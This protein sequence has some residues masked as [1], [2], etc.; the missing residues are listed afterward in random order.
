MVTCQKCGG[1]FQ[2][3]YT[4]STCENCFEQSQ[5]ERKQ[6]KK[7]T[8]PVK[9]KSGKLGETI[10]TIIFGGLILIGW[11]SCTRS[12]SSNNSYDSSSSYE[13]TQPIRI[14]ETTAACPTLN[15]YESFMS[16]GALAPALQTHQTCRVLFKNQLI[17]KI[18]ERNWATAK[19]L[20]TDTVSG[21]SVIMYVSIESIR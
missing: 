12:C 4:S 18:L 16:V 10:F 14:K 1:E 13:A 20:Y 15:E 5:K 17:Q 7:N 21:D 11:Q 8:Q 3:L 9:Q 2:K 19:V 6:Q